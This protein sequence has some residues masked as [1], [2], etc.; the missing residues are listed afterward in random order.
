MRGPGRVAARQA[1]PSAPTRFA[2][3]DLRFTTGAYREGGATSTFERLSPDSGPRCAGRGVSQRDKP[4]LLRQ[5]D[6]RFAI[7]DLRRGPTGRA[8][9][10]RHSNVSPLIPARDARVGACRSATSP[11]FCANQ[12]CDLRFAIYD[13]GLPGGRSYLD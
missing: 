4:H 1:P 12:I 7:R 11:T 2:I 8:E 5:P 9:L 3:C 10:P 13:G 6:L